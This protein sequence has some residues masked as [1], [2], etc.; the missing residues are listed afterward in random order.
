MAD[1]LL[2]DDDGA[3]RAFAKRALTGDGHNVIEVE[4]GKRALSQIQSRQFD[5]LVSDLDMPELDG[6]GLAAQV[7]ARHPNLKI[8]LVSGLGDELKRAE[9]FDKSKVSTLA[10]PF[11]LEQ[12]RSAVRALIA[13]GSGP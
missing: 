3:T 4:D 12:L 5:V 7:S 13:I 6:I 1:I 11:T 10:K 8:L 9:G 2:A